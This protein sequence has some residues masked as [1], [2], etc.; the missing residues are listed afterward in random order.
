[1][2]S[3]QPTGSLCQRY[4]EQTFNLQQPVAK[5]HGEEAIIRCAHEIFSTSSTQ[6]APLCWPLAIS[7]WQYTLT[8]KSWIYKEAIGC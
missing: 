2:P 8:H 5:S 6:R 1:M 4:A 3:V 7:H